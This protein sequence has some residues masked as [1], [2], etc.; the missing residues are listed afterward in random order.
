MAK[1]LDKFSKINEGWYWVGGI[2]LSLSSF[3]YV[4][5]RKP[6]IILPPIVKKPAPVITYDLLIKYEDNVFLGKF[7]DEIQ[8]RFEMFD[9]NGNIMGGGNMQGTRFLSLNVRNISNIGE[10]NENPPS[11]PQREHYE[12]GDRDGM[13]TNWKGMSVE[14]QKGVFTLEDLLGNM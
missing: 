4:A 12:R 10:H 13:F 7:D 5:I 6:E 1:L 11:V 3:W 8:Y 2:A 14:V 9:R